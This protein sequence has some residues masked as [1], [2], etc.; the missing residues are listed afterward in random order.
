MIKK[1]SL[2]VLSA[3]MLIAC[4]HK[5]DIVPDEVIIKKGGV[6][7]A[8]EGNFSAA[9]SSLSYYY[10]PTSVVTNNVFYKVNN[11]PL[12]DV[13]Q[14]ITINNN[15]VFVVI[16]NSGIIYGVNCKT[17]KFVG[18]IT[19]LSS[20]REMMFI[21]DSKAY[22]S[23]L[24]STAI[25]IVNP[26]NFKITGKIDL[27]RSSDCMV[28]FGDKVMVANWSGYNQTSVNNKIMVINTQADILVDS[29]VVG[30]EPNSMIVDKD[31]ALW[32]L[33]SGGYM[34]NEKASLWKINAVNMKIIRQFTFENILQSPDNLCI[35]SSGDSLFFINNG[36]YN[37]SVY[38]L[39]LPDVEI[40]KADGSNFYS[41]GIDP[42]TSEIYV[43]D[44]KDY[45]QNGVIY[46]YARNGKFISS[47]EVGI[48]PGC[49]TF[50]PKSAS[51]FATKSK[52]VRQE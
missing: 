17:M 46:R 40:V 11:V 8:N 49:F 51:M 25:T 13:A 21:N 24:Y 14:S 44:A 26:N 10:P 4:V 45:T 37:M 5:Q 30:I 50:N 36:V 23:D 38:D 32:V 12:G 35:N 2:L 41:L 20:P 29:L 19:G 27:G 47:F 3:F 7:I 42:E 9:N 52:R 18:K 43:S 15:M 39:Q 22:V 28:R 33:C 31:G 6:F 16:N 48:I 1:I 34:N